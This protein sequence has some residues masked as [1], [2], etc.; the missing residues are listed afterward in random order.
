[1]LGT[2]GP[3][4]QAAYTPRLFPTPSLSIISRLLPN[5]QTCWPAALRALAVTLR[6][7]AGECLDVQQQ[8]L[9]CIA[10]TGCCFVVVSSSMTSLLSKQKHESR[11]SLLDMLRPAEICLFLGL[12]LW[13]QACWQASYRHLHSHM[14]SKS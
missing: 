12:Y 6:Q 5:L 2:H 8:C 9:T 11:Y 14:P 13:H 7:A 10:Q 1:M 4:V 3:L